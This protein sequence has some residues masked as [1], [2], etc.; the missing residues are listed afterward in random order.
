MITPVCLERQPIMSKR[1]FTDRSRTLDFFRCPRLRFYGYEYAGIGLK[2]ARKPMPFAVGSAVH[3][4]LE[5]LLPEGGAQGDQQGA[6]SAPA[7]LEEGAVA[8][9]LAKFALESAG[10]LEL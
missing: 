1:F 4:G 5:Y 6:L 7:T 8:A 3:S 2:M 9:A 10:G